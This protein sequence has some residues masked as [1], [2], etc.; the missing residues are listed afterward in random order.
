[1]PTSWFVYRYL[2]VLIIRCVHRIVVTNRSQTTEQRLDTVLKL[3]GNGVLEAVSFDA[4]L[5]RRKADELDQIPLDQVAATGCSG[6]QR[7]AH[8]RQ[9]CTMIWRTLHQSKV[10]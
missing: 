6:S 4:C 3:L 9:L 10:S 8:R 5:Y 7:L 1:M 2:S